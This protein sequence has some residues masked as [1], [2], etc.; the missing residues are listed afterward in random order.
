MAAAYGMNE[1]FCLE[2]INALGYDN[3]CQVNIN[4]DWLHDCGGADMADG[5]CE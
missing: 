4:A 3:L 1:I 5:I 2:E